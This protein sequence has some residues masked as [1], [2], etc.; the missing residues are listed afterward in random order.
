MSKQQPKLD[1]YVLIDHL[2]GNVNP[3][4]YQVLQQARDLANQT[5]GKCLALIL[6]NGQDQLASSLPIVDS[7]VYFESPSLEWFAPE[8][9]A[10]PLTAF[11][12][13]KK[14]WVLLLT[15]SSVSMDLAG[16]IA[17][18]T[19]ASLLLHCRGLA[20]NDAE[21]RT[22]S[23]LYS[24][25]ALAEVTC[26]GTELVC[27]LM[28][29]PASPQVSPKNKTPLIK[30][31]ALPATVGAKLVLKKYRQAALATDLAKERLLIGIGQGVESREHLH[32][33]QNLCKKLGARLVTTK[34]L[35]GRG[36]VPAARK[37]DRTGLRIA[38]RVYLA[39]G[40]SEGPEHLDAVASESIIIAVTPDRQAAIIPRAR[41][42]IIADLDEFLDELEDQLA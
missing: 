18:K 7:V 11:F 39:L 3:V 14:A 31:V 1:I 13:A 8:T 15:S 34:V 5:G 37:V 2:A 4:M 35:S 22:R 29:E 30:K 38:P 28:P 17:L 6:G 25:K 32:R 42:G 12:A 10:A 19:N 36:W 41:Y 33:I 27:V 9:H 20:F 40:I 16:K 21:I 23:L 26:S 24:G